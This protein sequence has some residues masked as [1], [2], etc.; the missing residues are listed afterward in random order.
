MGA[1]FWLRRFM[2]AFLIAATA[3]FLAEIIKGHAQ[4]KAAQF[5]LLWGAITALLF[6]LI[7]YSRFKRNPRCWLLPPDINGPAA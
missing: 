6:T 3:L 7:S 1:K 2:V 5:A 4:T